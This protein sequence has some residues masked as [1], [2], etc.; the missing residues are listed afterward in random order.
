M[1]D[2]TS[3]RLVDSFEI[4]PSEAVYRAWRKAN[5]FNL[6]V[7]VALGV[8]TFGT[9]GAKN[10]QWPTVILLVLLAEILLER[11]LVQKG[12]IRV[13]GGRLEISRLLGGSSHI[14]RGAI[15]SM[16]LVYNTA[17][18]P[19]EPRESLLAFM[20]RNGKRVARVRRQI[21][22]DTDLHALAEFIGAPL[23]QY[24]AMNLQELRRKHPA[25]LTFDERHPAVI[26]IAVVLVFAS[27]ILYG[28]GFLARP[29]G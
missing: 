17:R 20:G 21:W 3:L 25:A 29:G 10:W 24:D 4:R 19:A 12:R 1:V 28:L 18:F 27:I 15:A 8:F 11:R 7:A 16:V 2:R 14:P 23:S 22:A 5:R 6:V 9:Y 13:T 26:P